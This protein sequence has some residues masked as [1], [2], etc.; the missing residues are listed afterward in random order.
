MSEQEPHAPKSE[1]SP[2]E[3]CEELY[4][5]LG[6][7]TPIYVIFSEHSLTLQ[8]RD[9]AQYYLAISLQPKLGKVVSQMKFTPP[10]REYIENE[11]SR[12]LTHGVLVYPGQEKPDGRVILEERLGFNP[13]EVL[14]LFT[15]EDLAGIEPDYFV[16]RWK[17][18]VWTAD[19]QNAMLN[20]DESFKLT[21][22]ARLRR[23]TK[24]QLMRRW[25]D[26]LRETYG[27]DPLGEV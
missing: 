21:E 9:K 1:K 16:R 14:N 24:G 20:L 8:I 6:Y 4:T 13:G 19:A 15:G 11:C 17:N 23:A 2:E 25:R 3:L 22:E 18:L 26:E 5:I 7:V 12:F 10:G 27:K